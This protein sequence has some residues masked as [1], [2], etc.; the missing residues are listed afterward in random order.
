MT[1]IK[2]KRA[3]TEAARHNV[4]TGPQTAA[5]IL[6]LLPVG[7]SEELSGRQIGLVMTAINNGYQAGRIAHSAVQS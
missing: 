7:L 4:H 3:L 2:Y 6:Q 5:H 1:T